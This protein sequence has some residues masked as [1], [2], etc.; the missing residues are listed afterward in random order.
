VLK[1]ASTLGVVVGLSDASFP[2]QEIFSADVMPF[3]GNI[4]T[5]DPVRYARFAEVLKTDPKLAVGGPTFGWIHAM[6][7]AVSEASDPDFGPSIHVPV[8]LIAAGADRVVS[9][10]AVARMAQEIRAGAH[11]VV[12]GARHEIMM[13]RDGLR[14]L[15][16][17]AF[18]AFIPGSTV[19]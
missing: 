10:S 1:L 18:D 15:F 14:E 6:R 3:P 16:W 2:G 4:V 12:P 8:L 5:S 17:A 7:R 13:E 9:S 19:A 11:V